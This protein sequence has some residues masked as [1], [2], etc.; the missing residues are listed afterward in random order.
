MGSLVLLVIMYLNIKK[1]LFTQ[2]YAVLEGLSV[3]NIL[4]FFSNRK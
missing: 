2:D 4:L 3:T 1:T